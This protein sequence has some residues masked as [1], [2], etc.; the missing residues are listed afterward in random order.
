MWDIIEAQGAKVR[1]VEDIRFGDCTIDIKAGKNGKIS[2][3]DNKAISKIA[4]IAGCPKDK[5][6]GIYLYK[7]VG[8]H[9]KKGDTLF[10]IYSQSKEKL[11]F[12][13]EIWDKIDGVKIR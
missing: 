9:V 2:H 8:D 6:A 1:T 11:K 5:G 3:I 10:K 12:A 7:H 4:R 13:K